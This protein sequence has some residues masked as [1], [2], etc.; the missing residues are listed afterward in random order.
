M[1]GDLIKDIEQLYRFYY[2]S[3]FDSQAVFPRLV[4]F[5]EVMDIGKQVGTQ[6][7]RLGRHA[8]CSKPVLARTKSCAVV[9][10]TQRD[11]IWQNFAT[12]SNI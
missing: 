7:G 3:T 8:R 4:T 5:F 9:H 2:V 12:F 11:Q 10:L 6:V 1:R